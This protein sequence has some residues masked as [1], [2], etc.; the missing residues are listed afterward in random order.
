MDAYSLVSPFAGV[1][2]PG[3]FQEIVARDNEIEQ[4]GKLFN[5]GCRAVAIVGLPGVGKTTLAHV[6]ASRAKAQFPGGVTFVGA[7]A[8]ETAEHLMARLPVKPQKESSLLIVDDIDFLGLDGQKLL[9]ATLDSL[10]KVQLIATSRPNDMLLLNSFRV[11]ELSPFT[12]EEMDALMHL[13][14]QIAMKDKLEPETIE[15]LF[16]ATRGN[17]ALAVTATEAVRSG[18]VKTWDDLFRYLRDFNAVGL[19]D[20]NGQPLDRDSKEFKSIILD[21]SSAN[22]QLIKML[23]NDPRLVWQLPPRKFE[24]IVAEILDK[25]GYSITLTPASGDGGVD[26]FAAKK[27]GLGKFLYLVECKRYVPPNKV[28]VEVVRSLYGVLHA[29]KATAGAIVTSSYFTKGA[30]E[31]Q[32]EQQHQLQLHDYIAL[33]Q[34]VGDF[35]FQNF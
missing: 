1:V 6:F 7:S 13:R 12:M 17:P 21:V 8:I 31:F 32:R 3:F 27:D 24:E 26:I 5:E 29:K 20:Q 15:R 33:N 30:K 23:K 28:G 35:P 34:W 16:K 25:Q 10:P 11:L 22:E 9:S 19:V 14:S 18:I 2:P 4:L